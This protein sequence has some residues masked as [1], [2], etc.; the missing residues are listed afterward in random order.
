MIAAGLDQLRERLLLVRGQLR[1]VGSDLGRREPRRCG[2][3]LRLFGHDHLLGGLGR[4]RG[5]DAEHAANPRATTGARNILGVMEGPFGMRAAGTAQGLLCH[6]C[7]STKKPSRSCPRAPDVPTRRA[8]GPSGRPGCSCPRPAGPTAPAGSRIAA[9]PQRDGQ[10]APEPAVLALVIAVPC[11]RRTNP[12]SVRRHRST[13]RGA[14][15]R[16]AAA[17]PDRSDRASAPGSRDR[18]PGRCR[19]RR[20]A[21]RC[22]SRSGSGNRALAARSSGTRGSASRRARAARR[23]R[24]SDTPRGTACRSPH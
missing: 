3:E 4:R 22:A 15:A 11:T 24:R 23:A 16:A 6:R 19:S 10:V 17:T 13:R 21:R 8:P 7:Q 9:V 12:S 20:R 2:L 18:R 14:S 1:D 5:A